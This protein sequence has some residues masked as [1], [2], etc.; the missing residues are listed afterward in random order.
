VSGLY[1]IEAI[2][3][4]LLDSLGP[5]SAIHAECSEAAANDA[6]VNP[7]GI[8]EGVSNVIS[9]IGNANSQAC[10]ERRRIILRKISPELVTYAAKANLTLDG[11]LFGEDLWKKLKASVDFGKD[12]RGLLRKARESEYLGKDHYF[13]NNE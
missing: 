6:L 5:L 4:R 7:M 3:S 1:G 13:I 10:R 12:L 2:Q 9:L 8:L 11:N